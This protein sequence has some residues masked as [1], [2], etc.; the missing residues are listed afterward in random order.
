MAQPTKVAS[1]DDVMVTKL[2]SLSGQEPDF[3]AALAV[4]KAL[5]EQ[6]DWRAVRA[7]TAGSPFAHAC[8]ALVEKVR[9][10]DESA[11]VAEP[12]VAQS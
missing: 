9:V 1:I 6:I 4:A 2:L 8:F 10:V 11:A 5:R 7:R 3:S 12:R